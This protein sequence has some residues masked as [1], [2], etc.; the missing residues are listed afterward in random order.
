[1]NLDMKVAQL[2][3]SRLCHDLISP[4][5]AIGAGLELMAEN[6]GGDNRDAAALAAT[7]AKQL[8]GKLAFFR[9][10]FGAAHQAMTLRQIADLA[11]GLAGEGQV[12]FVAP[13][14]GSKIELPAGAARVALVLALVAIGALPRG[15]AVELRAAALPEGTGLALTATG[16]GAQLRGDAREAL[17]MPDIDKLTARNVHAYLAAALAADCGGAVEISEDADAVQIATLLPG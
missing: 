12:R 6:P 7:S 4:A 15:G 2:L 14:A 13:D 10:A 16:K 5:G 8:S 9:A 17:A 1:M 3:C 11:Q